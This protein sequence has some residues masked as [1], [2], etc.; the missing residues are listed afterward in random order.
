M[1]KKYIIANWKC[2]KTVSDCLD[3]VDAVGPQVEELT[4]L[5][6]IVCPP[7]VALDAVHKRIEDKNFHLKNGAQTVSSFGKGAYTGET[8][9][10]MVAGL[11]EYALLGH[12]ERRSFKHETNEDIAKQ[13]ENCVRYGIKPIVLIRGMEDTIPEGVELFAWEP[14]S[15][16]GTGKAID[17]NTA[18]QTIT[19][20]SAQGQLGIYGGS[21][22]ASN[23]ASFL[24][25]PSIAGVLIGSASNDPVSFMEMIHAL[26]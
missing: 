25:Q 7:A 20:L 9:A 17:A 11:V 2:T 19:E 1:N 16:I 13:V 12:S 14:V 21:V 26:R 8:G 4:D 18:Q 23:I 5:E 10:F 6:I 3:W 22:N 24:E 15:A